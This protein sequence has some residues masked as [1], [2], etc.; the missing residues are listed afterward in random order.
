VSAGAGFVLL[1]LDQGARLLD[2]AGTPLLE[3][4]RDG[5]G[6]LIQALPPRARVRVILAGSR[7]KV[8][9]AEVPALSRSERREVARR[10]ALE[11]GFG[12]QDALAQTV[13]ADPLAEG[14]Q[15]L[16]LA[17]YPRADL[18]AWLGALLEAGARPLSVQVWQRAALASPALAGGDRLCLGLEPGLA[19]VL[20]VHGR[21]LRYTRTFPL[22]E[23]LDPGHLD[24]PGASALAELM[25]EQLTLLMPFL[26]RKFRGAAPAELVVVGLTPE[27]LDGLAP[28]RRLNGL[29]ATVLAPDWTR[30]LLDGARLERGLDLLPEEIRD[31]RR[32]GLHRAL[33]RAALAGMLLLGAAARVFLGRQEALLEREALAAEAAARQRRTLIQEGEEAARLRFGFLRVR[34]AEERQKKAVEQLEQ[35]ATGLFQVPARLHLQRV[36]V[37][38]AQGQDLNF[39][40]QVEGTARS[41][42]RLSLGLLAAYWEHLKGMPGLTLEPM[43]R[44]AVADGQDRAPA[45][46]R[47]HLEGSVR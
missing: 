20:Y 11:A 5:R 8:H 38:R 46:T 30:F 37:T 29:A 31:A 33:V 26:A 45:L 2:G 21:G 13:D 14:G 32:R 41:D 24:G 1:V 22:P 27:G 35:A 10:L 25:H 16:W 28:D 47:F 23:G 12:P 44:V 9:C 34:R 15:V 43:P 7:V 17:G 4:A 3:V 39:R 19:R 6:A 40:F 36:T 42:R 18:E